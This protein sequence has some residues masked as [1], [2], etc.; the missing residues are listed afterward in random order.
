MCT[1]FQHPTPQIDVTPMT[2]EELEQQL[3]NMATDVFAAKWIKEENNAYY[4]QTFANLTSPE[5]LRLCRL[6]S[7][8]PTDPFVSTQ[9]PK[10]YLVATQ[11][12]ALT[13]GFIPGF[14]TQQRFGL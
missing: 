13:G 5:C 6:P 8:G 12:L 4:A 2:E 9:A 10:E 7:T 14:A 11:C 3:L 1:F